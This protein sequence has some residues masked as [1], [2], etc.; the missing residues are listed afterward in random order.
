MSGLA[1]FAAAVV[2]QMQRRLQFLHAC[3]S[4]VLEELADMGDMPS[5]QDQGEQGQHWEDWAQLM[6][7]FI[8]H[9]QEWL[10]GAAWLA[11]ARAYLQIQASGQQQAVQRGR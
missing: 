9:Q 1:A 4:T 6:C 8:G 3:M 2:R 7:Y 5:A 10:V 11:W